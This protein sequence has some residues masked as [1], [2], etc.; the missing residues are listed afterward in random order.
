MVGMLED[1]PEYSVYTQY[2][3]TY[4]LPY[5]NWGGGGL[6]MVS[7]LSGAMLNIYVER[8]MEFFSDMALET[9]PL[10][11]YEIRR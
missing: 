1:T 4:Y 10:N 7:P 8:I 5:T 2:S 11:S 9:A 6:A 3:S